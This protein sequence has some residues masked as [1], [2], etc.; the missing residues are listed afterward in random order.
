V[1]E[2]GKFLV[3]LGAV[4]VVLGLLLWSGVGSGWLGRLPGDIRIERGN[5]SFYFP[6]VT[7]IVISIVLSLIFSLFRR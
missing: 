5:S 6:I 1:L 7:C 4:I 3:V 2:V